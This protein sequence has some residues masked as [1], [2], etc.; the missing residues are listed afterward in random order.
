MTDRVTENYRQFT[1]KGE[2]GR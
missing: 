2:N 1:G